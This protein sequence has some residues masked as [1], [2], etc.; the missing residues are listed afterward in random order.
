MEDASATRLLSTT[1][2]N[3]NADRSFT[4]NVAI[5]EAAGARSALGSD[6]GSSWW[7]RSAATCLVTGHA[8]ATSVVDR[9]RARIGVLAPSD[10]AIV[11]AGSLKRFAEA[12][13]DF[14]P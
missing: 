13:G 4:A 11:E 6:R 12:I 5:D 14:N 10:E 8:R 9:L 1:L 7:E 2:P 3:Q